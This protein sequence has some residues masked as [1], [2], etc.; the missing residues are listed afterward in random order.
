MKEIE[1]GRLQTNASL[2][3]EMLSAGWS[4]RWHKSIRAQTMER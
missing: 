2:M 3:R 1:A 4:R